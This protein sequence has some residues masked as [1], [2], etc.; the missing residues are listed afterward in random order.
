MKRVL[1]IAMGKQK[2]VVARKRDALASAAGTGAKRRSRDPLLRDSG[3]LFR[4][5]QV[6]IPDRVVQMQGF[7]DTC[8]SKPTSFESGEVDAALIE[9]RLISKTASP[10]LV[11]QT[12]S[13]LT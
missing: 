7:E 5:P 4:P 10:A 3:S 12:R 2:V 6:Q 8:Y 11:A 9:V 1:E 13:S